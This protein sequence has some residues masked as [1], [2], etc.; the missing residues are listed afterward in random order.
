MNEMIRQHLLGSAAFAASSAL[1]IAS[2]WLCASVIG[3][4]PKVATVSDAVSVPARTYIRG[5][6]GWVGDAPRP[7]RNWDGCGSGRGFTYEC[8]DGST[9]VLDETDCTSTKAAE[10]ELQRLVHPKRD[11]SSLGQIVSVQQVSAGMLLEYSR[12]LDVGGGCRLGRPVCYALVRAGV[13][14]V[15]ILYGP[16]PDHVQEL[17]KQLGWA[18]AAPATSVAPN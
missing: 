1:G 13:G 16:T 2:V 11:A 9:L 15:E 6:C 7:S 18:S 5:S 4:T 3:P 10:E 14:D 17:A 8:S 12:P